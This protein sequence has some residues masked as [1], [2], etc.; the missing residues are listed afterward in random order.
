MKNAISLTHLEYESSSERTPE[1]LHWHR[2]FKREFSKFLT[3]HGALNI[4]IAKPNHFDMHGFFTRGSQHWYFSIGDL[5]GFKDNM[6][7]RTVRDD[8]DFTGGP[9]QYASLKSE[10]A[11]ETGF[12]RIVILPILPH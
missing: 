10:E 12:A 11:F 5:R 3:Q 4:K 9:N 8:R 7:I 6:L 1:Y 2:T